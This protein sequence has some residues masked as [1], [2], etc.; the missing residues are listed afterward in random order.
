MGLRRDVP[1]LCAAGPSAE[2]DEG[3][4]VIRRLRYATSAALMAVF[5]IAGAGLATSSGDVGPHWLRDSQEFP[6][7]RCNYG[8]D[9]G[10]GNPLVQMKIRAPIVQAVNTG[11]GTQK[12]LVGWRF[13][14]D[15]TNDTSLATG[16]TTDVVSKMQKATAT[17]DQPA[18]F[19]LRTFNGFGSNLSFAYRV[20]IRMFWFAGDGHTIIG[21][22]SDVNV[23]YFEHWGAPPL[24]EATQ[25]NGCY[26]HIT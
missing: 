6:G 16:W 19:T 17:E 1:W 4:D 21:R 18:P 9:D 15:S 7:V 12:Q 22:A 14:I 20:V 25:Q 11:K 3:R 5:I 8:P 24:G 10:S 23:F 26:G 2:H 13:Q